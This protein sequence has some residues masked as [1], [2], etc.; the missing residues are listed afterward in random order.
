MIVAALILL[1]ALYIFISLKALVMEKLS[2]KRNLGLF[3]GIVAANLASGIL[4]A[5][6]FRF[7]LVGFLVFGLMKLVCRSVYFFKLH[8]IIAIYGVKFVIEIIVAALFFSYEATEISIVFTSAL[9]LI[10]PVALYLPARLLCKKISLLWQ[11]EN[12]FYLR[13]WLVIMSLS[14]LLVYVK[15]LV[16]STRI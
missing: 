14:G 16:Q 1:E 11:G 7:F 3:F 12:L 10:L 13:F 6:P 8:L 2:I 5:T 4:H 9:L 15:L